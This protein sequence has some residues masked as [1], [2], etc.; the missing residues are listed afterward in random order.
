MSVEEELL[1]RTLEFV[2]LGCGIFESRYTGNVSSAFIYCKIAQRSH[3][4]V[5]SLPSDN[6]FCQSLV[7]SW[8][9]T[10]ERGTRHASSGACV[11]YIVYDVEINRAVFARA[12]FMPF[13]HE[14]QRQFYA[15]AHVYVVTARAC[16]QVYGRRRHICERADT[17]RS[18][19][20]TARATRPPHAAQRRTRTF[21]RKRHRRKKTRF[22]RF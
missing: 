21:H 3:K 4:S 7:S 20:P 11:R 5:P 2:K 22:R 17:H 6:A 12:H 10:S 18:P 15:V 13:E 19:S 14:P 9:N 16:L 8:G 1:Q